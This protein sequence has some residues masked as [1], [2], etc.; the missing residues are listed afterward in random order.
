[1]GEAFSCLVGSERGLR[2]RDAARVSPGEVLHGVSLFVRPVNIHASQFVAAVREAMSWPA[3]LRV[4]GVAG[5]G[6]TTPDEARPKGRRPSRSGALVFEP[7]RSCTHDVVQ[8][9]SSSAPQ[10]LMTR[11]AVTPH[12]TASM[13]R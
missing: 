5:Y 1:M 8:V 6:M 13:P 12:S 3:S 9:R 7:P 10:V 11:S 4:S 2:V